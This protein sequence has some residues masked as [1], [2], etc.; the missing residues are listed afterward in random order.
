[1][2]DIFTP[3]FIPYYIDEV[4]RFKLTPTEWILY[5]FI[6]FYNKMENRGF[7]FTSEQLA[8]IIKTTPNMINKSLSILEQKWLIERQTTKYTWWSKRLIKLSGTLPNS[9]T[10]PYQI[11]KATLP[12]S[13]IKENNKIDNNIK[14]N[15]VFFENKKINDVFCL[16]I[17]NRKQ[18]GKSMTKIWI[19]RTIKKINKWLEKYNENEVIWFIDLSI[20]NWWQGIFEKQNNQK[21]PPQKSAYEQENARKEFSF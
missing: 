6:R 16:F 21:N 2:T 8:W 13:K 20:D 19:D 11:V 1:M 12:N 5:G 17:E 10:P 14:E 4:E 3:E 7:Y 18:M 15:N 9:K